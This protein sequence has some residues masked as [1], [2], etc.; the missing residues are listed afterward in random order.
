MKTKIA[1]HTVKILAATAFLLT[2]ANQTGAADPVGQECTEICVY[3]SVTRTYSFIKKCRPL[4]PPSSCPG[5]GSG[6]GSGSSGSGNNGGGAGIG[7]PKGLLNKLCP[8]CGTGNGGGGQDE[9]CCENDKN[10]GESDGEEKKCCPEEGAMAHWWVSEPLVKLFLHDKPLWYETSRGQEIAFKLSFKNEPA[11]NAVIDTR[12]TTIFSV[13]TNWHTPWRSYVQQSPNGTNYYLFLGDGSAVEHVPGHMDRH[14]GAYYDF[15]GTNHFFTFNGG[16]RKVYAPTLSNATNTTLWFL[17]RVE[18][19]QGLTNRFQYTVTN[20]T[21]RLTKVIDSDNRETT[22]QYTNSGYYSHLISK[23]TGP[24]GQTTMLTY[25]NGQLISI[26][27]MLTPTPIESKMEYTNGVISKLITPYGTNFFTYYS[28]TGWN[29]LRVS[30][31]AVRTNFFLYGDGPTNLFPNA[32]TDFNSLKSQ[33]LDGG[34]TES[35]EYE[36]LHYRNSYFWGAR[37]Y[38]NLSSTI[39]G[40]LDDGTFQLSDLTASEFNKGRTRHWLAVAIYG[41]AFARP[42]GTT[43]SLER[44]PSPNSDGSTEGLTIWYDYAN[45][46]DNDRG[47]EGNPKGHTLKAWKLSSADWRILKYDRATNNRI[48]LKKFN[49]G[50]SAAVQWRTITNTYA[51]NGVDLVATSGA[52]PESFTRGFNDFHQVLNQTNAMQEVTSYTYD[53]LHRLTDIGYPNGLITSYTYDGNGNVAT[54]IDHTDTTNLRTNSYTWTNGLVY[55]HTDERGLTVTN[56]YDGL[57][58][59]IKTAYPDGTYI[60]NVYTNLDLVRVV[61]RM[62]FTNGYAYN[63]FGQVIRHTNANQKV[64]IYGYCDCGTL[65]S[66]TDPLGNRTE[67]T[68]DNAGRMTRITYPGNS[69]YTDF[70]YDLAGRLT[71]Q[72]DGSGV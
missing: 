51:E 8:T 40:K 60:T 29:G 25:T 32:T 68:F 34:I 37:Q 30:E 46:W 62:G 54:Q 1:N 2:F 42:A 15:D 50:E 45:K 28:G 12:Q 63:S 26:K 10:G 22:F 70:A 71:T 69:G 65:E 53:N 4:D 24:S 7:L 67:Y 3:N 44:Q 48:I 33:L 36:N 16:V 9:E 58:R 13:G 52:G 72:T 35:L 5:G 56:T 31:N 20:G 14:S 17:S 61:D 64:T 21:V 23:V 57:N 66:V 6:S 18:Y 38:A 59:L 55:T 39:R 19:P 47:L 11:T 49:Y 41:D 27:D 43:L